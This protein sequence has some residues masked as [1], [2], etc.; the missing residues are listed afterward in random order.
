MSLPVLST[1]PS[2]TTL[3]TQK[4]G[5]IDAPLPSVPG[6]LNARNESS[7][8]WFAYVETSHVCAFQPTESPVKPGT[9]CTAV[10]KAPG[11]WSDVVSVQ[12]RLLYV[13]PL[14]VEIWTKPKSQPVSSFHWASNPSVGEPSNV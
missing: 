9:F 10:G 13:S 7:T 1:E 5:G 6:S 2:T 4:P 3:S 11:S 12:L 8:L 14:S